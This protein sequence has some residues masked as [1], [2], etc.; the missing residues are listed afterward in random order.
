MDRPNIYWRSDLRLGPHLV[1]LRSV[2]GAGGS[3]GSC[4]PTSGARA[5]LETSAPEKPQHVWLLA[6]T[7]GAMARTSGTTAGTL[8]GTPGPRPGHHR[9]PGRGAKELQAMGLARL[10]HSFACMARCP[11]CSGGGGQRDTEHGVLRACVGL[12]PVTLCC[13]PMGRERGGV[14]RNRLVRRLG[15]GKGDTQE[16]ARAVERR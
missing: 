5:H 2:F 14:S 8:V 13:V 15:R 16:Q 4:P 9:G 6:C 11:A 12:Y 10:S 3:F 7:S 1:I